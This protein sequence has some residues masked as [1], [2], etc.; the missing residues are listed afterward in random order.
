MG[1]AAIP[2][3]ASV[4]GNAAT[5]GQSG[6]AGPSQ[7]S[8]INILGQSGSL[9]ELGLILQYASG[10]PVNGGYTVSSPVTTGIVRNASVRDYMPYMLIGGV[11][12]VALFLLKR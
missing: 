12:L 1:A 11:A 2:A 4:A 9:S 3:F 5:G 7:N 8:S 10:A 6:Q